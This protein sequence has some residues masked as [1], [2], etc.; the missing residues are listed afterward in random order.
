VK[1]FLLPLL[2]LAILIRPSPVS[3][4]TE[5]EAKAGRAVVRRSGDAIISIELVVTLNLSVGGRA[6]PPRE[7][8]TE[9]NGTVLTAAGLTVTALSAIDPHSE[10]ER[11]RAMAGPLGRTLKIGEVEFKQVKLRLADGTEVAARV[12]LKD[13]FTD[14]AFVAPLPGE[15]PGRP[16]VHVDLRD[17]AEGEVLG[18]YF[19][20]ART[21]QE[22]QRIPV[23]NPGTIIGIVE[24]PRRFFIVNGDRVGSPVFDL[25]GRVLGICVRYISSGRAQRFIV[26]P[27]DE[28]DGVARQA[29]VE[30][31][32]P[33]PEPAPAADDTDSDDGPAAAPAPKGAPARQTRAPAPTAP[34]APASRP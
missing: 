10:T 30:A 31:A 5:S 6:Q 26:L 28:V 20:I 23:V 13:S 3:A 17:A 14:L 25:R 15:A 4:L 1:R 9:V 22:L 18:T 32:K 7:I 8:R 33:P 2:L 16:F 11:I 29:A 21:S 27:A 24:K 34:T 19:D 12:V